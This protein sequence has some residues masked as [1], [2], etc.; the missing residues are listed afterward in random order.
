M[1]NSLRIADSALQDQV[2]DIFS[3][4]NRNVSKVRKA[5]KNVPM[6]C[7]NVLFLDWVGGWWNM[8]LLK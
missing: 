1:K 3:E 4:A 5:V 7:Y 8:L 6:V 2:W